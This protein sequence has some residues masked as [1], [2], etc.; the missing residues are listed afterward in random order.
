M[1]SLFILTINVTGTSIDI[2]TVTEPLEN[3]VIAVKRNTAV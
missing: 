1:Q 2:F 3:E